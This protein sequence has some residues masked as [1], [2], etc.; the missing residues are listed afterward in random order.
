MN[1]SELPT[2]PLV[3]N[4]RGIE[5]TPL[6]SA[7]T[8]RTPHRGEPDVRRWTRASGIRALLTLGMAVL[9]GT[10]FA[11]PLVRDQLRLSFTHVP[12]TYTE[13]YFASEPE[14]RDAPG[15]QQVSLTFVVANH[16]G[17]T[18]AAYP[19]RV[20]LT[21]GG[22]VTATDDGVVTARP[23]G[24]PTP[25]PI[26]MSVPADSIDGGSVRVELLGRSEF[27]QHLFRSTP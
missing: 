14:V 11:S 9:I 18:V 25:V 21:H 27:I 17:Q 15:G 12:E 20:S 6:P 1:H 2:Q 3:P 5:P 8:G 22:R 24:D 13:L 7:G 16:H 10:A 4:G 23:S 26:A 19:Y